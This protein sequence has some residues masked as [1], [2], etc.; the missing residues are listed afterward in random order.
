MSS[1][2]ALKPPI[3]HQCDASRN[4]SNPQNSEGT[5]DRLLFTIPTCGTAGGC[6]TS[7]IFCVSHG[8]VSILQKGLCP[9]GS[10]CDA[11]GQV[12]SL[13]VSPVCTSA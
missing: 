6:L 13:W 1:Q 9:S 11:Q 4:T 10:S 5:S 8:L 2:E 3:T 12:Q 7:L